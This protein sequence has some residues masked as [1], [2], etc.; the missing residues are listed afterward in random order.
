MFACGILNRDF[1]TMTDHE[2]NDSVSR[3]AAKAFARHGVGGGG[4]EKDFILLTCV[5]SN[6]NQGIGFLNDPRRLNVAL[7]RS[8]YGMVICGNAKVLGKPIGGRDS[9][10]GNLLAHFKKYDLVVEGTLANLKPTMMTFSKV[11]RPELQ[12]FARGNIGDTLDDQAQGYGDSRKKVA[13]DPDYNRKQQQ[14]DQMNAPSRY[15]I[16][17]FQ[18]QSQSDASHLAPRNDRRRKPRSASSQSQSQMSQKGQ[19]QNSQMSSMLSQD[20]FGAFDDI[21]FHSQDQS[22]AGGFVF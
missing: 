8:R 5:R 11:S 20:S 16:P 15:F 10:W 6:E 18:S 14:H 1:Q 2:W 7:T 22:H 17:M 21:R 9:L 4:R 19:T 12:Y 13:D 3:N